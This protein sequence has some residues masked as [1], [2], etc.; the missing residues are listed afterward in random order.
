VKD[1]L[2]MG[3]PLDLILAAVA[4]WLIPRFWPLV[5]P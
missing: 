1:F 5:S 4:I 3:I 2:R